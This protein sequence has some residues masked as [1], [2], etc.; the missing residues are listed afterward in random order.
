L[1]RE[2]WV[3]SG[4]PIRSVTRPVQ[5]GQRKRSSFGPLVVRPAALGR[6]GK[7]SKERRNS[8]L[9]AE[10]RHYSDRLISRVL[11]WEEKET[12]PK[13]AAIGGLNGLGNYF[14]SGTCVLFLCSHRLSWRSKS[15][16]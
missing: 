6:V 14:Y 11:N 2:W 8:R 1:N 15:S 3:S 5:M 4:H 12:G 9:A 10:R 7:R 16:R 13:H